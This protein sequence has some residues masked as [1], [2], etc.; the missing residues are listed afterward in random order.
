MTKEIVCLV[1]LKNLFNLLKRKKIDTDT[2][3]RSLQEALNEGLNRTPGLYKRC[4]SIIRID[5][6]S[7]VLNSNSVNTA[8]NYGSAFTA[9]RMNQ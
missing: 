5:K 8:L 1:L 9:D 7:N 2:G 3:K 4:I 6:I